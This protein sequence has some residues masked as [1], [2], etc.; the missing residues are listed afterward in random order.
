MADELIVVDT[1]SIDQS[2]EIATTCGARVLEFPWTGHF[3]DARNTALD[4]AAG[5]WILYLDADE[6]LEVGDPAGFRSTLASGDDIVVFRPLLKSRSN[7]TP[8]R[9]YRIFR[10]RADLRFR[11]TMH[12]TIVPDVARIMRE[13]GLGVA[14]INALIC[15]SGY[16]GDQSHKHRRDLPLLEIEVVRTPDRAYLWDHIGRI[17]EALGNESAAESAWERAVT[18]VRESDSRLGVD[19]LPYANLLTLRLVADRPDLALA[20]EAIDRFPGNPVSLWAGAATAMAAGTWAGAVEW[21]DR[22][23]ALDR[24]AIAEDALAIDESLL[25]HAAYDLK[26]QALFEL[27]AFGDAEAAFARAEVLAPDDP[28]YRVRRKLASARA[29]LAR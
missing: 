16:D 10:N 12:E 5:H 1:G 9:E 25:G 8:Y 19:G 3:S 2:R 6:V 18:I 28:A 22:L 26:G 7:W 4:A 29:L 27:G 15:H 23:L 11:G 21:I 20:E 14:P 17:H 24:N 13:E